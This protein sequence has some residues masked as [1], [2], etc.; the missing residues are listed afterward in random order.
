VDQPENTAY[1]VA[2]ISIESDM[3]QLRQTFLRSGPTTETLL[4]AQQE[5]QKHLQ[6]WFD[7]LEKRLNIKWQRDP[8]P[9]SRRQ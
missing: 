3:D 8:A 7:D 5:G 1:A 6:N 9:D 2:M 4:L